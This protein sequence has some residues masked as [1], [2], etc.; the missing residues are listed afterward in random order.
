MNTTADGYHGI[1]YMN[2]PT[3]DIYRYKYSG[4]LGTYCAKHS[5]FAIYCPQVNKTFFCFGGTRADYHHWPELATTGHDTKD[6]PNALLH[7]V[8][9]YDHD[10]H[11]VCKPVIIMDKHTTD[12]HDNPVLS[13]DNK[14][15]IWI[16]S[17]SHGT[18]R[19]SF[20]HRSL[21]PWSIS[22]FQTIP[23]T[24]MEAGSRVPYDNFSYM[25]VRFAEGRGFV[26]FH[27]RYNMPAERTIGYI[28]SQNGTEWSEWQ[29]LAAIDKGHYQVSEVTA[30]RVGTAFNYHPEPDGLNWRTNLYYL[31]SDDWGQSWQSADGTTIDV[32]VTSVDN[33][34]LVHD[35][36]SEGLKVYMKDLNFDTNGNPVI[37]YVTSKGYEP[38][39]ENGPRIWQTAHWTGRQWDILPITE[40][41]SNYD[42]GCLTVEP[43]SLTTGSN[44]PSQTFAAAT[45]DTWRLIA[46]IG[47]GPQPGNPG[48]E[49]EMWISRTQ[50]RQWKKTAT[51]TAD[52]Q[53]NHTYARR[54]LHADPGFWALWADGHGRQPSPSRL[55][56]CTHD[57][58][59][60]QLPEHMDTDHAPPIALTT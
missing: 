7:M 43:D 39:P 58:R 52:S 25:Q 26:A 13:I 42:T 17:T 57:G 21:E 37:L 23:A 3:P 11:T 16:F 18:L 32:P 5:P 14:G 60:W 41:D 45:T 49:M 54:V 24:R 31:Q 22:E 33:R 56:F 30:G 53:Y 36:Q 12:A 35:Y 48:G 10:R 59:V 20:I 44:T 27:T 19:P 1:W 34:A 15:Y 29:P 55:Y 6:I 28:T 40:S 4:G 51:L 47:D 50:G 9:C 46:P 8:G 2:Q 38:G